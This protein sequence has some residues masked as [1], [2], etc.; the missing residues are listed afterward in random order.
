MFS[1]TNRYVISNS[2]AGRKHNIHSFTYSFN[3]ALLIQQTFIEHQF[4]TRNWEFR[5]IW[6]W[7]LSLSSSQSSLKKLTVWLWVILTSVHLINNFYINY[8]SL[9]SCRVN[10]VFQM[11]WSFNI[12]I[13][14][15]FKESKCRKQVEKRMLLF[16]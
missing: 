4:Y 15:S 14:G 1:S 13:K 16:R 3:H 8:S 2:K 5:Q 12:Y 10:K 6:T 11:F 9:L 7:T